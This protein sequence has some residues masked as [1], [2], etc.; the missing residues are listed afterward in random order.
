M[1]DGFR[2]EEPLDPGGMASFWRVSRPGTDMPLLMKVPLM[3][4]GEDRFLLVTG[5]AFGT[6]DRAW[7]ERNLPRDGSVYVND[8]TSHERRC[9]YSGQTQLKLTQVRLEEIGRDRVLITGGTGKPRPET[10]KVNMGYRAGFVGEIVFTYSWPD[11]W[12]KS[13]RG[14]F[15]TT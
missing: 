12:A 2:L 3:R 9:S 10:L 5:T 1:I 4:R 15:T 14:I 13:Q 7:L 11:A 6:H 8:V